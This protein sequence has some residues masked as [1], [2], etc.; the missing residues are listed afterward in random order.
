MLCAFPTSPARASAVA[1][2]PRA[3]ASPPIASTPRGRGGPVAPGRPGGSGRVPLRALGAALPVARPALAAP[4]GSGGRRG[5]LQA[6]RGDAGEEAPSRTPPRPPTRV[7]ISTGDVSGD[8]HAA[9]VTREIQALAASAGLE[10]DVMALAGGRTANAG[11]RMLGDN[12]G[13]S[14]I[15]LKEAL[16]LVLPSL[17]LQKEVRRRLA[18]TPPDVAIFIDYPGVNIPFAKYIRDAYPE[19]KNI[20]YIPPNE[21][22]WNSART[23]DIIANCDSVLAVYPA[24]AHHFR[25][26]GGQRVKFVGHPLVDTVRGKPGREE[27]RRALGCKD[28]EVVVML[29]PASRRQEVKLV[30]PYIAGAAKLLRERV[31]DPSRLR[32]IL[33]TPPEA[34]LRAALRAAAGLEGFQGFEVFEGD[35]HTV[36]AA[37]DLALTKSGTV[38]VELALFNVPQVRG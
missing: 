32:F 3:W 29:T 35:P 28:G 22:L 27:A 24:E 31:P 15:G 33:A 17:K 11:G 21:W 9:L 20:Y 36:M 10:V 13:L 16:P 38:N 14:S 26:A 4:S 25:A 18:E 37:S 6:A 23:S 34:G 8:L 30:W 1:P 19:C 12:T 5:G 7:L 2:T